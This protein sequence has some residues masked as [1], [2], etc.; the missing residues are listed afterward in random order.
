MVSS[1]L[2]LQMEVMLPQ[3]HTEQQMP[4]SAAELRSNTMP[5]CC[6]DALLNLAM[7]R[8]SCDML[9]LQRGCGAAQLAIDPPG[10]PVQQ[11]RQ[12]LRHAALPRQQRNG[13]PFL[14][15][16]PVE[17][18]FISFNT[19]CRHE[20][21][22]IRYQPL[23]KMGGWSSAGIFISLAYAH[24]HSTLTYLPC[25]DHGGP[26]CKVCRKPFSEVVNED[27]GCIAAVRC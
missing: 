22:S 3:G 5:C 14:P 6:Q 11:P 18:N 1:T 20:I 13:M 7:G 21:R 9:I 12:A 25:H 8:V 23:R 16:T 2:P 15:W 27:G 26:E 24:A 17:M 10:I 4:M 19:F